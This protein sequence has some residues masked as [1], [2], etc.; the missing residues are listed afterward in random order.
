[1][2]VNVFGLG[3]V[4]CVSAA[5]LADLGHQ[6]TGIDIDQSKVALINEGRSP[7]VEPRLGPL[8]EKVVASGHLQAL[9]CP[10]AEADVSIMCVGTPSSDNGS[11]NFHH[12]DDV[13][14]QI[15]RYLGR[16]SSYHVVNIRSTVLPGT[17]EKRI[18]PLLEAQSRKRAG[19]DFGVCMNPEFMR[20]GS[21]VEDFYNP[22]FTLIGELDSPSGDAVAALYKE[23]RRPLHRTRL[24]VAEMLKYACNSF[25]AVKVSF[26]NEIGNICKTLGIDSHEVMQLLCLDT[27]LNIS[28][29]YMKPGFAFGGSCLP[30][31]LRALLYKAREM[32][33]DT[34]LL[35]SILAS[36]RN[37]IDVACK[38]IAKTDK[39][40]VGVLGLSFKPGTDDLRDS[41]VVELIERLIGKGYQVTVYD[42]EVFLANLVGANKRYIESVIPHISRLMDCSLECT[43]T[44][45][46]V[47]V[48]SK[49]YRSLEPKY[50]AL[51]ADRFVI[52]LVR[53]ANP[54]SMNGRYQGICW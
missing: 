50:Q 41:P 8:V 7:I 44:R 4:G 9:P 40:R 13:T 23:I 53:V 52:D 36:N 21:S 34:P 47:V 46:D 39:K 42:E 30:K 26:S 22:P 14:A 1:M 10:A 19:A 49:S 11:L 25:H 43:I 29:Y 24:R 6:V 28:P 5:C 48:I 45:S 3:Y 51:L 16:G 35:S 15:G 31:D 20:E 38:L 37:Q 2:K 17:V 18:I 12:I 33:V 27:K 32:D 54:T